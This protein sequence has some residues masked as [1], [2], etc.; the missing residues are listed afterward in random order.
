MKLKTLKGMK[1]ITLDEFNETAKDMDDGERYI[2]YGYSWKKKIKERYFKP[3]KSLVKRAK[4]Y[5]KR[6]TR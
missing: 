1:E 2:L 3:K 6:I 4:T 5:S